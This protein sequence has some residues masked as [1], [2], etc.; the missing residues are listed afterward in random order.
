MPQGPP[1]SHLTAGGA[2]AQ[3]KDTVS[4]SYANV[5]QSGSHDVSG[6]AVGGGIEN[7]LDVFG[8][9][10]PN[11][12]ARTEYLYLGLGSVTDTSRVAGLSQSLTSNLA[13]HVFRTAVLYKF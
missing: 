13:Q 10:G 6:Y 9:L 8:L 7:K 2:F 1:F 11:W 3:V 12:T 5:V 4:F